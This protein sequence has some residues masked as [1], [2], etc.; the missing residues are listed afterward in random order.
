MKKKTI[1]LNM[2]VKNESHVIRRCLAC[3][4]PIIDYWVIVDTGSTDETQK[5]IREFLNGIPGELHERPWVH[6][7]HNRN[8]ALAYAKNKGDYLLFIDADD[9]LKWND[10]FRWPDLEDDLYYATWQ[11]GDQIT[12]R[13]ILINNHLEWRW[14]GVVHERI[15]PGGPIKASFIDGIVLWATEEGHRSGDLRQK[16]LND[17][18]L[19]EEA[20]RNDSESS[21]DRFNL[22]MSY[23]RA[24]EAQSALRNYEMR[25]RMGGSELE[26]YASYYRIGFLQEQ[27]GKSS[28]EFIKSYFLAFQSRPTRAEPLF[29][30]AAYFFRKELYFP[31]YLV[32]RFALSCPL[33]DD[34]YYSDTYVYDYG[35]LCLFAE[36]AYRVGQYEEAKGSL[37]DLLHRP[38]L[39][40]DLRFEIEKS[41]A[42]LKETLH[43]A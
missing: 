6:F 12:R 3:V 7:A 35:L 39:P 34:A 14:E 28:N 26:V 16:N 25:A 37:S 33:Q 38:Q 21:F 36:C 19:L 31:A 42:G 10:S 41:A 27:L 5:I 8:E 18:H 13:T 2:I 22:A 30:I 43:R 11:S 23:D 20:L 4:K 9:E 32:A 24:G 29:R 1:C 17:A 15:E 40:A